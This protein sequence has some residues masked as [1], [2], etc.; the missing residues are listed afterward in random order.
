MDADEVSL[1]ASW[2][3]VIRCAGCRPKQT[4][5]ATEHGCTEAESLAMAEPGGKDV[6]PAWLD[7]CSMS[8]PVCLSHTMRV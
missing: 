3:G 6:L 1:G 5:Q 2:A 8:L 7:P 4:H